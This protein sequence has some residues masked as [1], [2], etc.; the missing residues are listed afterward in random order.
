MGET[1]VGLGGDQTGSLQFGNNVF[2]VFVGKLDEVN[3]GCQGITT[4]FQLDVFDGRKQT[5]MGVNFFQDGVLVDGTL[6]WCQI[7][8]RS[9][10]RTPQNTARWKG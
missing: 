4:L 8:P 7:C 5:G 3:K 6:K 9:Y 1:Q 10:P 2:V